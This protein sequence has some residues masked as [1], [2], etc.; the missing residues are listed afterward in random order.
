MIP[1]PFTY[2]QP[3]TLA[4][5]VDAYQNCMGRGDKPLYFSG[6]TEIITMGRVNS[7][8]FDAVID[9]KKIPELLGLW[10][11]GNRLFIGAAQT[12]NSIAAW[13]AF[14][15]LT[16]CCTRVADHTAQCKITLGGNIAGT[17][18]YHEAALPLL[19]ASAQAECFGPE[20]ARTVEISA[21]FSQKPSL[22]PGEFIVRFSLNDAVANLPY[23]HAKHV[24]SE[25]IGYPLFT[26]AAIREKVA[27]R[28][29]VSGMY[30]YPVL[31]TFSNADAKPEPYYLEEQLSSQLQEQ[32]L[33]DV[34]GSGEYRLF[35]LKAA[36]CDM[37]ER[38]K[39]DLH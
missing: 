3:Q 7:L 33:S 6:G 9:L 20:G 24:D 26:L 25:K 32:P 4:E 5:A 19:L 38:L 15:L 28:A 17:I 39:E 8:T 18:I 14:P 27:V 30:S 11:D 13:N 37:M 21:L 36:L 35:R 10:R 34:L 29:A 1:F 12:L 31:L 16:K 22:K 2:W 23:V